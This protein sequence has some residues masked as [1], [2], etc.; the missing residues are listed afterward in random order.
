MAED[1][2]QPDD[3]TPE[4]LE[5]LQKELDARA[6][7][8][9]F[10]GEAN[11]LA[12]AEELD[13]D[14]QLKIDQ[15]RRGMQRSVE[16][17]VEGPKAQTAEALIDELQDRDEIR[18]SIHTPTLV[19]FLDYLGERLGLR[20]KIGEETLYASNPK[21][22]EFTPANLDRF[23]ARGALAGTFMAAL[24]ISPQAIAQ[25]FQP[26][27][28][29][30]NDPGFT[31]VTGS[32]TE[33]VWN[34]EYVAALLL[35]LGLSTYG[36]YRLIKWYKKQKPYKEKAKEVKKYYEEYEEAVNT[37]DEDRITEA[38]KRLATSMMAELPTT[39]EGVDLGE[40]VKI[41][42]KDIEKALGWKQQVDMTISEVTL[43]IEKAMVLPKKP[44]IK[45]INKKKAEVYDLISAK[46]KQIYA[47]YDELGKAL[48]GLDLD[49]DA[50][51]WQQLKFEKQKLDYYL[52]YLDL[53][54]KKWLVLIQN[55]KN[56]IIHST[57]YTKL[58]AEDKIQQEVIK[59]KESLSNLLDAQA[60]TDPEQFKQL[61]T[62]IE[63]E[64]DTQTQA[65][66]DEG[67]TGLQQDAVEQVNHDFIQIFNNGNFNHQ[68]PIRYQINGHDEKIIDLN[69]DFAVQIWINTDQSIRMNLNFKSNLV[70]TKTLQ[71]GANGNF[72]LKENDQPLEDYIAEKQGDGSILGLEAAAVDLGA[73]AEPVLNQLAAHIAAVN[74][75]I[76]DG[77]Y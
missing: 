69:E 32:P 14:G 62:K 57:S 43:D 73:E 71:V 54:K 59:L 20:V 60:T 51:L 56:E 68:T 11:A 50:Y 75:Q 67:V 42:K 77:S 21:A 24:M 46:V 41:D 45:N 27:M 39:L 4:D 61:L 3:L 6:A 1:K 55:A 15:I 31:A 38:K 64:L 49:R 25:E 40:D 29:I 36:V 2:R 70:E 72:H 48:N 65:G 19:K 53:M 37:G 34:L 5:A 44:T 30:F 33:D 9:E 22:V 35:L 63:A 8:D 13:Q 23:L 58:A 16:E 7:E 28:D 18:M 47:L 74:E 17:K 52:K 66:S 26:G 76:K 12:T 10:F